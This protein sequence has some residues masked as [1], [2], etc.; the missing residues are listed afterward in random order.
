MELVDA[1]YR[2]FR[3][4]R[5]SITDVC[6]YRCQY[7][8]PN[9]YSRPKTADKLLTL[10]EIDH[11]IA[12]FVALGVQK[13]RLTGGEPT[14]RRD[15]IPLIERIKAEARI[16][17][18]AVTTN[19]Y[20]LLS[21]VQRWQKAGLTHLNIS[22]DSLSP[23][24]FYQITGEN[25]LYELV[26]GIDKAL[27]LGF[28]AV[29]V[30][31]VLLKGVTDNLNAYLPWIK[32]R[33]I[34]LRFIELMETGSGN[35]LF[36]THHISGSTIRNQLEQYGWQKRMR[37]PDSGP[38]EVFYH[39]NY[40]GEVG[41]I[42]PYSDSFC[43]NCNRLRVSA[44]GKL[45]FCLFGE[46]GIPLRDLLQSPQQCKALQKRI[47]EGIKLKPEKHYLSVHRTGLAHTLSYIGG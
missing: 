18:I 27:T 2:R 33:K 24:I 47:L 15:F 1:Y 5:L 25:K 45:H 12:A 44:R 9:G 34:T 28:D 6:N 7:C 10:D 32:T 11:I 38:A 41:L 31:T 21:D 22:M 35:D 30:N 3:Y 13:I 46:Y 43:K 42:M 20:R 40:E 17:I 39:D 26:G 37:D 4:L 36:R 23:Q 19:G 16:R 8:L 14:I 29:K